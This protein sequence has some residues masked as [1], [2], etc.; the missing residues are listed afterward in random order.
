[1]KKTAYIGLFCA[2][3]IILGYVENLL[4]VFPFVPGVRLGITN[5]V[6]VFLLYSFTYKEAVFVSCIRILCIGFMFG[7]LF[8][9][10][11]SL[12]GAFLSL[13]CMTLARKIKG[14]SMVG[15]SVIGGVTHNIGQ[16]I[17]AAFIVESGSVFFYFPILLCA[18]IVTG[19]LIGIVSSEIY[20]R[21]L[22]RIEND[23]IFKR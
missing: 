12:A 7:N 20:K 3:A 22:G 21:M 19:F 9:I 23:S 1:M 5:L 17:I 4:P 8:S 11:Y 10:V 13:F 14:L 15:V 18:G 2:L 16:L 6:T